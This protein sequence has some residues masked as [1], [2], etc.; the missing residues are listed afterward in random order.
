MST[1]ASPRR[2]THADPQSGASTTKANT[3]LSASL[4]NSSQKLA[5]EALASDFIQGIKNGTLDPNQFGQ[6]TIQDVLYCAH[7]LSDWETVASRA[8]DPDVKS[9]ATAR[10]TSWKSYIKELFSDWHIADPSAINLSTAVKTYSDLESNV[11][12]NYDPLYAAVVMLPCDRLWYWLATQI[13]PDSPTNN[14]YQFWIAD[15][16][17]SDSGAKRL[18]A[19]IDAHAAQIDADIAHHIFHQAM[20]G[21]VNGFRSACGQK[22]LT[23]PQTN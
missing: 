22:L 21:E 23:L 8:T 18:E 20:L 4:W 14:V 13:A 10:V 3:S 6:Y 17:G 11:A 7:G 16:G 1:K 12:N 5:Q 19:F 9:F 2:L 15:N